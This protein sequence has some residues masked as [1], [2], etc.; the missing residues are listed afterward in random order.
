MT[1]L[2]YFNRTLVGRFPFIF[3]NVFA[4]HKRVAFLIPSKAHTGTPLV[5]GSEK[6]HLQNKSGG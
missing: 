5:E 2:K 1:F 4:E 6:R 3:K